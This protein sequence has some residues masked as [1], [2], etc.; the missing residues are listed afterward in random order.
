MDQPDEIAAAIRDF[1]ALSPR[2]VGIEDG[3]ILFDFATARYSVSTEHGKCVLQLWSPERSAVR[4]V[5]AAERKGDHLRLKV[6]RFGQSKPL[7]LTLTRDRDQRTPSERRTARM[8]YAARLRAFLERRYAGWT[9]EQFSTDADL[10]RSFS[11]VYTRALLRQGT[12]S[13][14][15]IGINRQEP[16]AAIDAALTIGILWLDRCRQR[17]TTRA[18][19]VEGLTL[20]V[21]PNT[22]SLLRERLAHL[23]PA[24]ARWQLCEWDEREGHLAPL[25][26]ADGGNLETRLVHCPDESAARQRFAASLARIAAL[27][28][29]VPLDVQVRSAGELSFRLHGLEVARATLEAQPGSFR[30]GEQITFG[31]GANETVLTDENAD[32][33]RRVLAEAARIRRPEGERNHPLWR[34]AP[35]RWLESLVAKQVAVLDP[36]LAA[37]PVY[38]QVPAMAGGERG[39]MDLLTLTRDGRLAVIELKADDDIHLPLQGVD[40][41]A[42]VEWHRRRGEFERHG[43]FPGTPLADQ[44][45]I[46]LLV[47][48]ALRVHP[49]TDTVLRYLSPEIDVTL[50]ALDEHWRDELRVIFRK[51]P[52]RGLAAL[53]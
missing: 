13:F 29:D 43:Y 22:G 36:R 7:W 34:M 12:R 27:A 30:P 26:P 33:F 28:P 38:S 51:R 20:L 1:L 23:H 49:A 44:P 15:L 35:E 4:R 16:Q 11:S 37:G 9:I 25:D 14:A 52:E 17:G 31:A 40:Y 10:Q 6:M 39:L 3:V 48:P 18:S 46:L 47:C 5:V 50:V 32:E 19:H 41:W 53:L 24:A 42:R 8:A 2:S 45:P 21:P